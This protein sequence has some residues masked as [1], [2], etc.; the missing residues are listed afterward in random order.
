[1]DWLSKIFDVH[2]LPFKI[3]LWVAV[4]SGILLFAPLEFIEKLKISGLLSSYGAYVGVVFLAS[5]A[6]VCVNSVG[7]LWGKINAKVNYWKWKGRIEG[8]LNA[9]DH[10]EKAVLRE[11]YIQGKYTIELPMDNSTVVGLRNKQIIYIAG[12][13]GEYSLAGML[14]PFAIRDEA[15]KFIDPSII[16]LPS[17]EPSESD[18]EHIRELRPNFVKQIERRNALLRW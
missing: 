11:F 10:A 15:R 8:L 17:G 14:I 12:K 1:M 13:F 6:L 18:I 7:W 3:I 2:K 16:G 5:S 4:V 9:L